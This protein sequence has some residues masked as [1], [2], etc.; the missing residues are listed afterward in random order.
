MIRLLT[1]IS[2]LY[3]LIVVSGCSGIK[4][5]KVISCSDI[6]DNSIE[7]VERISGKPLRVVKHRDG[8]AEK[9]VYSSFK[10]GNNVRVIYIHGKVVNCLLD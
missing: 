2:L 6:K 8:F 3:I 9:R 1:V 10:E 4:M 5:S 7:E